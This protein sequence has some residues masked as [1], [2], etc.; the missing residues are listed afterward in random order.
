[1]SVPVFAQWTATSGSDLLDALQKLDPCTKR[2]KRLDLFRIRTKLELFDSEFLEFRDSALEYLGTKSLTPSSWIRFFYLMQDVEIGNNYHQ[3]IAADL[4]ETL[5]DDYR[6]FWLLHSEYDG[7]KDRRTKLREF[8]KDVLIRGLISFANRIAPEI[9]KDRFFL[10]KLN[11]YA[12]SAKADLKPSLNRIAH[13]AGSKELRHFEIILDLDEKPLVPIR[14]TVAFLELLQRIIRGY[15][16]NKHDKTSVV[17]LEE[18]VDAVTRQVRTS[19][20]LHIQYGHHEWVLRND[21][22]NDEIVVES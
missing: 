15:R 9:K 3:S 14:V 19:D 6:H 7:D 10:G 2:S 16:P 18:L 17:V 12:M 21:V 22:S 1:M 13:A 8:Y 5:F 4:K 11:G 20:S